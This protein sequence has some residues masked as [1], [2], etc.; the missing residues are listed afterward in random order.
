MWWLLILGGLWVAWGLAAVVIR[1]A[2]FLACK[3]TALS[4]RGWALWLLADLTSWRWWRD[5]LLVVPLY[6]LALGL[7]WALERLGVSRDELLGE[8]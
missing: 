2:C 7:L 5:I 6:L 8:E 1:V 3:P 4:W